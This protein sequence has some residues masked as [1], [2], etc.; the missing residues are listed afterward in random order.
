MHHISALL[1]SRCKKF[2]FCWCGPFRILELKGVNAII[3]PCHK[4]HQALETV[5]INKLKPCYFQ[6]TP[7]P[8]SAALQPQDSDTDNES[9]SANKP[10]IQYA[11]QAKKVPVQTSVTPERRKQVKELIQQQT[12]HPYNLCSRKT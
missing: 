7:E 2:A 6:D 11:P 8:D 9:D 5:H 1:T 10:L 12:A 4:P 3:R